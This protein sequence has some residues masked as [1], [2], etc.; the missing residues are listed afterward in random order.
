MYDHFKLC[1][2]LF[3]A[4]TSSKLIILY[5]IKTKQP[6]M[7]FYAVINELFRWKTSKRLLKE[8]PFYNVPIEKP[9]IKRLNNINM[10]REFP[11]YN[12]LNVVKTSRTFKAYASYTIE[13]INSTDPSV[14]LTP[15]KSGIKDLF[16]DL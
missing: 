11:F 4:V 6:K 5:V 9:F 16:K 12:E 8:L 10:L 15:H 14:Q 3:S 1:S 7:I 2:V 13:K